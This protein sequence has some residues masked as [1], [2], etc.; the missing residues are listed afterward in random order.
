MI[1]TIDLRDKLSAKGLRVTPQR[2]R[3]LE[4]IYKLN[5]HPT[6]ENIISYIRKSDPN[7]GSGTVYNVLETLVEK[8]LIKK[9]KTEKDAMRYDGVLENHH[10]LYCIECDYIEDFVSEKLDGLLKV[11]FEENQ[12]DNFIIDNIKLNISGNFIIHKNQNH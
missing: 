2:M 5:N 12:I 7:V 1:N 10:H 8:N 11:F 9:V 4:A 6:A 3:V